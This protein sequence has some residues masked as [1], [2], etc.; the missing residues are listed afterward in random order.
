MAILN[1]RKAKREGA[2]VVLGFAGQ[3][4]TGK[5]L[6]ALYVARGMVDSA[7]EIGFLDTENK[8]GSLYADELD[9]EFLIADLEPPF[10]PKRYAQ[11]IKE[12]QDA[13]VKVLVIDS[14][15]HE[16]EGTGG[17]IEIADESGK[18]GWN[19]AKA[20]H[21]K[22]MNVLLQSGMHIIAC[23]RAR[24]QM[25]FRNPSK[26][27]DLGIQPVAE[28][29]FMF[30]MTASVMMFNEGLNQH[31][32]KIPKDLK[33]VF[34]DGNNYLGIQTGEGIRKWIESGQKTDEN[35]IKWKSH[36]QMSTEGGM[37]S[38]KKAWSEIPKEYQNQ[39]SQ[40]KEQC[41]ASAQEF[42][43]MK[44]QAQPNDSLLN[45]L[46]DNNTQQEYVEPTPEQ[47]NDVFGDGE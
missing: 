14:V 23:V 15:T 21:K 4:G 46:G 8:R 3:S 41:K 2:K 35:L 1:I 10:S 28:K 17:C 45:Q 33:P 42:D 12:F 25:D 43:S 39:L 26:P 37:I 9:G 7:Q 27:I 44:S 16:W 32:L 34:G 36:L 19:K 22:Y 24:Q 31:H 13:G 29:N 18:L 5:T 6:T 40:Y 47:L 30:E 38:L 11:A 20:E